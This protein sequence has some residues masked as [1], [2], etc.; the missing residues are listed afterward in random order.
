M[1]RRRAKRSRRASAWTTAA[2]LALLV[3]AMAWSSTVAASTSFPSTVDTDLNLPA[4]WVEKSVA[5]PDGCLLCHLVESG[6]FGTNNAFGLEMKRNGAI[7]GEPQTVAG[8]LTTVGM[9]DPLAIS[10]IK[11]GS[12]PNDDPKWLNGSTS[13]DPS[14][15]YGCGSVS[16]VAPEKHGSVA[17]LFF[18][19]AAIVGRGAAA[20]RRRVNRHSHRGA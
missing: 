13:T 7:G 20:R 9:S 2:L 15:T 6:G 1:S 10:D 4:G 3:S 5:P 11:M 14:P 19:V 17:V 8:A 18:L 12:N 16:P